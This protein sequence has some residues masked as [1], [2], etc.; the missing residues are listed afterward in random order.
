MNTMEIIGLLVKNNSADIHAIMSKI[1]IITLMELDPNL[2]NIDD[3]IKK[4]QTQK[5][6]HP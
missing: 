5:D 4:T 6:I 3:T 2:M 1:G